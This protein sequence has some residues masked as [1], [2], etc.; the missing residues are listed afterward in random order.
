MAPLRTFACCA[1]VVFASEGALSD[2]T[3]RIVGGDTLRIDGVDVG[4]EAPEAAGIGRAAVLPFVR[5]KTWYSMSPSGA[6]RTGSASTVA[7]SLS[8]EWLAQTSAN[9]WFAVG[10]LG[11]PPVEYSP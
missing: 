10:S 4:I 6:R 3:V 7:R 1:L 5:S 9:N 11:V 2:S 8:A